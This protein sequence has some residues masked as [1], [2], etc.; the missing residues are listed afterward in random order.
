M[1]TTTGE[2]YAIDAI[3]SNVEFVVKHLMIAKVRGKFGTV[4]GAIVVPE[5]TNVPTAIDA[6][7]EVASIATGDAQRDGHLKSPDFFD[8]ATY[9]Q[10]AF[11]STK[12]TPDGDAFA[13]VGDL[14]MHGVTKPVALAAT[15]E[16]RAS[17]PFGNARIGYEVTG[18]L[19]RTEFG[20]VFN[21]PMETGGVVIGT[22]VKL[23]FA[24]EA[25]AQR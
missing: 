24:L 6:T 9:P 16:G 13:V 18:K 15:Y 14:T 12:I 8:V 11:R 23:E 25:I 21:M 4:M 19:D 10:I 1:T 17:D 20:L 22:E 3:H 5:G 2:T 7:I